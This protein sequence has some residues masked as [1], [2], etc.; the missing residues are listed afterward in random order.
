MNKIDF[1]TYPE[2]F[3][4]LL[5]VLLVWTAFWKALALWHSARKADT[6]WFVFFILINTVG[7]LELAYLYRRGKLRPGKL[8]KK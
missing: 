8:F 6:G 5:V 4:V 7:I 1:S 3:P 2:W